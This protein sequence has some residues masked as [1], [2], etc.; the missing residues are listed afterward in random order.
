MIISITNFRFYL[1]H[2]TVAIKVNI[3]DLKETPSFLLGQTMCQI[4]FTTF[5]RA[6]SPFVGAAMI[7][8]AW[9][10]SAVLYRVFSRFLAR[11]VERKCYSYK[12]KTRLD[13]CLRQLFIQG[14]GSWNLWT[15]ESQKAATYIYY[16]FHAF[17]NR[18]KPELD[19][20]KTYQQ[21]QLSISANVWCC[22]D[23]HM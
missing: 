18:T 19:R 3:V 1:S 6:V 2:A 22:C 13:H 9:M 14:H 12:R 11:P 8:L 17:N 4:I 5:S 20:L 21:K 16:L 10:S 23:L 7:C 15:A